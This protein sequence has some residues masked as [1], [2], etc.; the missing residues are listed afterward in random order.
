MLRRSIALTV[1]A[2]ALSATAAA[3]A[4]TPVM[5]V[6]REGTHTAARANDGCTFRALQGGVL[7]TACGPRDHATLTY[8]FTLPAG[9]RSVYP[10]VGGS[11]WCTGLRWPR[12]VMDRLSARTVHEVIE[13]PG[14]CLDSITFV[15]INYLS[16]G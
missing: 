12:A 10:T 5:W 6:F 15:R 9:V 16:S 14:G 13:I 11:R 8:D 1:V 2:A 4:T 3:A 7:V